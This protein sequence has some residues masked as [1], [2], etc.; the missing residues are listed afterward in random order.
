MIEYIPF[1]LLCCD[2]Y[3]T[4]IIIEQTNYNCLHS[5]ISNKFCFFLLIKM[6]ALN[7]GMMMEW[8]VR[9]YEK[10]SGAKYYIRIIPDNFLFFFRFRT[11]ENIPILLRGKFHSLNVS[12]KSLTPFNICCRE[13]C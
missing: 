5:D 4:E 11:W 12:K 2:D 13:F 1:N 8:S 6:N 7:G 3:F 9:F 10:F